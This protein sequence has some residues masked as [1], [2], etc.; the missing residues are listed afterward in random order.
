MSEEITPPGR[1]RDIEIAQWMNLRYAE[2]P[3]IENEE[4]LI[5]VFGEGEN[6]DYLLPYWST[7]GACMELLAYV[8]E[9]NVSDLFQVK[10]RLEHF[11]GLHD[12]LCTIIN[13]EDKEIRAEGKDEADAISGAFLLWMRAKEKDATVGG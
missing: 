9:Q 13:S 8:R 1:Q 11:W 3:P 6:S 5:L 10:Y 7:T 2:I 4:D 12:A